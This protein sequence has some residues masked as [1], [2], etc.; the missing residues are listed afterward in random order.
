[1]AIALTP[2]IYVGHSFID[3]YLGK[4]NAEKISEEAAHGSKSFF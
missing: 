2:L 3:K 1:V 4:E